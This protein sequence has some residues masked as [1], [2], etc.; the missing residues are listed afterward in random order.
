MSAHKLIE[1]A[2]DEARKE[3]ATAES[4][5]KHHQNSL[6]HAHTMA[7]GARARVADLELG[8]GLLKAVLS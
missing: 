3:Q 1:Q 4:L 5:V 7:Q 2:R 6:R 8:H